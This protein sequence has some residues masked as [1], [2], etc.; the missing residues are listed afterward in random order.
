LKNKNPTAEMLSAADKSV[1]ELCLSGDYRKNI[2][3]VTKPIDEDTEK[4]TIKKYTLD[5][6]KI[7]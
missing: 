2:S 3:K 7:L 6:S 4:V 1:I 5:F